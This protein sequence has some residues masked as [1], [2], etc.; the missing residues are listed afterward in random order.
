M[1]IKN[2]NNKKWVS[3]I[4]P[5]DHSNQK[6]G[7]KV[8]SVAR[9]HT[10]GQINRQE[11]ENRGHPFRVSGIFLHNLSSRIIPI[12]PILD[13]RLKE[14]ILKPWNIVLCFHFRVCL[15]VCLSFDLGTWFMEWVILGS[16]KRNAF[17]FVF[18]NFIFKLFI[19]IFSFFPI[20]CFKLL[21]TVFHLGMLYLSWE[22]LVPL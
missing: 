6:L 13:D 5:K 9:A 10:D 3:F 1:K 11:S 4:C 7:Q 18:W 19:G 8:F 15:C 22:N 17:F 16:W 12:G 14:K 2:F 20:S 21:V